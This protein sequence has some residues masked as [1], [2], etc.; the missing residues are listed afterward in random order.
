MNTLPTQPR[1]RRRTDQTVTVQSKR[2]DENH[3]HMELSD[4]A[5]LNHI[6]LKSTNHVLINVGVRR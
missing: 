1:R 3:N 5:N 4:Q 6:R 2:E